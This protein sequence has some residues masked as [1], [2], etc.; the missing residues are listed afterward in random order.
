MII[1][2]DEIKNKIYSVRG[3]QVMLDMDLAKLYQVEI[4]RLNE[5]VKRNIKRFPERFRFQVTKEEYEN[6]LRSQ[7]ATLE[8]EQ[9]KHRKY[10]PYVFTEQGISMLSAVL[11]SETAIDISIKIIDSFVKMR[12]FLVDNNTVFQRLDLIEKRRL[13]FEMKSEE[14]QKTTSLK[15]EK[16][17]NLLETREVKPKQGI[18]FDGEMFEAYL[19]TRC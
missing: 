10:M 18:F 1:V 16:V 14:K 11:K 8:K 4:K 17:L 6:I 7:N 12:R 9:G 19:T 13:S 2:E 5:Q 3:E 15:I